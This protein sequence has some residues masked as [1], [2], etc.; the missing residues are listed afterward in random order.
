MCRLVNE[1]WGFV[2]CI[3]CVFQVCLYFASSC[4]CCPVS[5]HGVALRQ[6]SQIVTKSKSSFYSNSKAELKEE[7]DR[8]V[9]YEYKRDERKRGK[10]KR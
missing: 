6:N 5:S 9:R 2:K 10:G 1:G 7:V 4:I 8:E 3:T